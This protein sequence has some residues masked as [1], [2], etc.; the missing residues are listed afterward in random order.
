MIHDLQRQ[1]LSVSAIARRVGV[2]RK[3]VRKYLERDLAAPAYGPREPRPSKVEP[4]S[5]YLRQRVAAFPELSAKRLLREIRDLGYGRRRP[6]EIVAMRQRRQVGR[7][8]EEEAEGVCRQ[9][10]RGSRVG[11]LAVLDLVPR[12]AAIAG[13]DA[14]DRQAGQKVPFAHGPDP[15]IDWPSSRQPRPG[16]P[17]VAHRVGEAGGLQHL[18]PVAPTEQVPGH[19]Q[20]AAGPEAHDE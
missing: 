17:M 10:R 4:F 9:R 5:D 7:P 18:H 20:P 13:N 19:L 12:R 14:L 16:R 11:E 2:D 8:L 15:L 6:R 1:G 3:T